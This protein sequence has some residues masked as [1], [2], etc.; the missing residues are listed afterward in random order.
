L[1]NTDLEGWKDAE[2]RLK[3]FKEDICFYEFYGVIS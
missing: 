2:F 3:G 1:Q